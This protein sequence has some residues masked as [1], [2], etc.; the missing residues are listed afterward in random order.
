MRDVKGARIGFPRSLFGE[1]LDAEVR[2]SVEAVVDV[3]RE[4]GAEVVEVELPNAKYSIAVYYIIATAEAS[5]NLARF[6]GARYGYRA[7]DAPELR[8][9]YRKTREEGFGAE[10][11]RMCCPPDTTKRITGKPSKSVR[12]SRKTL[13]KLSRVATPS[14]PRP[15]PRLRF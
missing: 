15:R 4:L 6:D 7:K 5:S 1:G 14:S 9:M 13:A 10:V 8:Q 11:K 12:C 2:A 3:Y